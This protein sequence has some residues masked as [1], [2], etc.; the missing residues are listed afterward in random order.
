[1]G[2]V[3]EGAAECLR[4][5]ECNEKTPNKNNTAPVQCLWRIGP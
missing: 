4:Q 1:M 2:W 3:T 5:K